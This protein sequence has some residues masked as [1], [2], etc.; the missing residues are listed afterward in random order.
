MLKS[1][2]IFLRKLESTDVDL[3][4]DWENNIENWEVSGTVKP[5][6][7]EEIEQ[8]VNGNHDIF[9]NKQIRYVI[10][11]VA[12]NK[13]I[14][15]VDLFEFDPQNKTVGVGVL[16][17]ETE[18]R[19]T[20]YASDSLNL[21]CDYCS[22]ELNVVTIFCNILKDNIASIRL[23]EKNGFQFVEERILFKK[24]INYYELKL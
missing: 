2:N 4:L 8:F 1:Q 21:I 13:A 9:E 6:T 18:N 17:A 10:C 23:F 14:G 20:G 19:R 7:K 3:I 16:I 24:P 12:N 22:N 15:T 5:F 11:L